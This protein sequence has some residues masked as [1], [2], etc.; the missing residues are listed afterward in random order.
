[1]CKIMTL[2]KLQ[3]IILFTYKNPRNTS[4][5][6]YKY[7]HVVLANLSHLGSASSLQVPKITWQKPQYGHEKAVFL[8]LLSKRYSLSLVPLI[9]SPRVEVK[10]LLLK[11]PWPSE[12]R[13]WNSWAGTDLNASSLMSRFLGIRRHHTSFH[14]REATNRPVQLWCPRTTSTG[15]RATVTLWP[16]EQYAY[17]G[18]K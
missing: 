8:V 13:H 6:M 9:N 18:S 3:W 1:M 11:T 5:S 12:S 17:L 7:K 15:Q 4:N 16:Q 2:K 14:K 10:S